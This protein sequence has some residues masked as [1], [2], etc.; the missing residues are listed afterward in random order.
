M[1]FSKNAGFH[2][3]LTKFLIISLGLGLRPQKPRKC[4]LLNFR[5]K[6]KKT[7]KIFWKI[8]KFSLKLSKSE[9]FSLKIVRFS[10]LFD[11][12][13]SSSVSGPP[14]WRPLISP[15]L[16]DLESL[17]KIPLGSTATTKLTHFLLVSLICYGKTAN[18]EKYSYQRVPNDCTE[19]HCSLALGYSIVSLKIKI[20]LKIA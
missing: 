19:N 5:E 4:M 15:L 11:N 18:L 2:W 12:F 17:E 16:I 3:F 9:R 13:K 1:N 20:Y 8:A 14:M 6:F 10:L 7:F